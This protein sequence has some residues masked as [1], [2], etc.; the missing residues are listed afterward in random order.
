[1]PKARVGVLVVFGRTGM[2]KRQMRTIWCVGRA[3]LGDF[4]SVFPKADVHPPCLFLFH[5]PWHNS[6]V[7]V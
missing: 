1:M 6:T 5:F 2:W 4:S 7:T 3:L